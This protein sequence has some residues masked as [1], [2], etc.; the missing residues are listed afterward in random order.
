MFDIFRLKDVLVQYKKD[1]IATQ[2]GNEKYKW[3]AA[4][5][6][7]DNW[8]VNASDFADMLSR[9]LAKT[10]NL[11]ASMNNFPARMI[12]GFAKTAPE[13]V[14]SMFIALFGESKEVYERVE[15]FK[16]Q[17]SILLEKY[18]NGAGQHYQYE[19]AITT[20]LWLRYPD[21]YYIYK[22]GEVKTVADEL[23]SDY[24]FKKGAYADNIRNFYKFY[25]EICEEL[26]Q[27]T[28]LVNLFKSQLTDSC[29]ADPK[30]K[31][32][33][34]DVGFYISRYYSQHGTAT[35][36]GAEWIPADYDPGLSTEDW[37]G[38]LGDE[39]V[40]NTGS[41]EIMKRMKDYGGAATCTQLAV[42]YGETKN[43]YNSG[44][45]SLAKRVADRMGL[46][47][48]EIHP[49]EERW[50][51]IL[52]IGKEAGKDEE[53]V[54][55]WKIR[56]ELSKALDQFDL[57]TMELYAQ[58][59]PGEEDHGYWWLNANPKIWSYS[60]MAVG[61]MQSYT[62]YNDNGNKRRIF[63]N[64]LDAKAGDMIIGYES[65]PVKQI[66][67]IGKVTAE[68][69]GEKI[70]FG[71]LEG[72]A[73]PIDFQ[74]LKSCP[75]LEKMEFFVNPNGSLFKLTRGE[76][77]FIMDM[78]RDENPVQQEASID[79]YSKD[80]FLEKVYMTEGRYD[81]LVA[82]LRN[83]KNIILQGAPGVGKTFTARRL[84]YSMMKEKD[85]SRIEFVQFHQ[86]Y[87]YEDFMMGYKPVEDGFE[88]KYGVFY[89]FCQKAANH[90]DKD[91]FFIIDEINRGNLSK[92]FGEL[93]M[94]IERDYRDTRATLAYN[95]LTF[96]VPS[97]LY[98]IGMMNT[99]DRSLAMIDYALRRRFSFFDMEPGFDSEGF[100]QYQ[101]G[102]QSETLN[103]LISKIKE[104]NV[105]IARDK[106]LGKG[107]CIGHSYFCE[108]DVCTDEWLREVVDYDILPM[109]SEYWFDEADKLQRWENI[110][111]GVFQ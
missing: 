41:L 11:L 108:K 44:A 102:L 9:S 61:E 86:N 68:Q 32:L 47:A 76:F 92:I 7:Q 27:D 42:K 55:T 8:D 110:L 48:V 73:S 104:L 56:D 66:V 30:L 98:I 22:F 96:F 15:A 85:D 17:S 94:L 49:G 65:N 35:S 93:L 21:K 101:N 72:L 64:F 45:S 83:K 1:F 62:L 46:S 34:I 2:W 57:S 6:F 54:F 67:A 107:F 20:Y 23:E 105:E 43:F 37:L 82:V 38:L 106:S 90:P 87:S 31:T 50:W 71:K 18:G 12:T 70:F 25:D 51:P 36:S 103:E 84:A 74:T 13:E 77:D 111:H 89:R 75:E 4:K 29:Y 63:Q 40:F 88:L 78:I 97:N 52:F 59:A 16:M 99:A 3:E 53:G 60:D 5:C 10:F 91:Y 69:D 80:D 33:T 109:L 26:Q 79:S 28:E 14:R 39:S 19:N 58:A 24:R 95:G 81:T 100:I